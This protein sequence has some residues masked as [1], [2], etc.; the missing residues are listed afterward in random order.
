MWRLA[1]CLLLVAPT[2][3]ATPFDPGPS[4]LRSVAV[5]PA[6]SAVAPPSVGVAPRSAPSVVAPAPAHAAR[7]VRRSPASA[8]Q[9]AASSVTA[10]VVSTST[11]D[12]MVI[13][14]STLAGLFAAIARRVHATKRYGA[15]IPAE[16]DRA[17]ARSFLAKRRS[18]LLGG[19]VGCGASIALAL[20]S[21]GFTHAVLLPLVVPLSIAIVVMASA[22][23]RAHA[24]T[25]HLRFTELATFTDGGRY[26]YFSHE[27]D[28]LNFIG[29]GR[30][31][32]MRVA[33]SIPA[34]R[35]QRA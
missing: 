20:Y 30:D 31:T 2:A 27:G 18:M 12:L 15:A 7:G 13:V 9:R 22:A 10:E 29:F 26:V 25:R 17:A 11:I 21:T 4:P 34:A 19:V 16:L 8:R 32:L 24:A 1:V 14:L 3:S 28:P 33:S 23:Y 35:V 5:A 6:P